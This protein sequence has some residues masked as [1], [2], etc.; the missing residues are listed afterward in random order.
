MVI[1]AAVDSQLKATNN[2]LK[3]WFEFRGAEFGLAPLSVEDAEIYNWALGGQ[4]RMTEL[5][6]R[7]VCEW[8]HTGPH[9]WWILKWALMSRDRWLKGII[10]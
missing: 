4:L 10:F 9:I 7:G 2:N 5:L 3:I 1:L 6:E 8:G